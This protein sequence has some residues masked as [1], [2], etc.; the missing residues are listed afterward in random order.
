MGRSQIYN[1]HVGIRELMDCVC[2]LYVE[3]VDHVYIFHCGIFTTL[4]CVSTLTWFLS[5]RATNS[6]MPS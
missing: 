3:S 4:M 6:R 5:D 1:V 2:L